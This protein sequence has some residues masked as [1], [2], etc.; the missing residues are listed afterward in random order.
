[1]ADEV[2]SFIAEMESPGFAAVIFIIAFTVLWFYNTTI[3]S[4]LVL[5]ALSHGLTNMVEFTWG[6]I[7]KVYS[8]SLI[9]G[10]KREAKGHAFTFFM[11]FL[12]IAAASSEYFSSTLVARMEAFPSPVVFG[13]AIPDIPLI[14]LNI[15]T[16][17]VTY[18]SFHLTSYRRSEE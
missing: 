6:K 7:R 17:V 12:F 4:Y 8:A 14:V 2:K 13:M 3:W 15:F 18:V 9:P 5:L 1:M 10:M 16:V 11:I